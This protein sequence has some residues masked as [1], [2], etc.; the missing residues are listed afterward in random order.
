MKIFK[1]IL[2]FIIFNI[3]IALIISACKFLIYILTL[4]FKVLWLS[5]KFTF[6][7]LLTLLYFG[8]RIL[9]WPFR[10]CFPPKSIDQ[11]SGLEFESFCS[12]WLAMEGYRSIQ[13]TPSSSD[14]GVDIL[15]IKDNERVGIQCK[16]YSGN[17]GVGAIQ[18][19][20]AGMPYYDCQKGLV[21]TNS[22]FTKNAKKLAEANNI[23]LID[24]EKLIKSRSCKVL[25]N[26]KLTMKI[27]L[28]IMTIFTLFTLY[29]SFYCLF[30][31][32]SLLPLIIILFSICLLSL[33]NGCFELNSREKFEI[34]KMK[35]KEDY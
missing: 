15:S 35:K 14:Y 29:L 27:S 28:F 5:I 33:I 16:R 21:I 19:I 2:N 20:T 1:Q 23:E 13:R 32:K 18:E 12:K 25:T 11:L 7:F 26:N 6:K 10:N 30:C 24:G 3:L 22:V 8:S 4:L 17:V 34:K 9:A 31:Y